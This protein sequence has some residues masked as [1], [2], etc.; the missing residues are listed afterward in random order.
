M[1]PFEL[2]VIHQN[3][4]LGRIAGQ[5]GGFIG[6]PSNPTP[7]DKKNPTTTVWGG[8][9]LTYN[10]LLGVGAGSYAHISAVKGD[11]WSNEPVKG[12]HYGHILVFCPYATNSVSG[13]PEGTIVIGN[14]D[15]ASNQDGALKDYGGWNIRWDEENNRLIVEARPSSPGTILQ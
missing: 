10:K 5:R 12:G 2:Q 6:M 7:A 14:A 8:D 1:T 13:Y 4:H 15:L 11:Y 9:H 3:T